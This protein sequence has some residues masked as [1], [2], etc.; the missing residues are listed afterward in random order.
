VQI[1]QLGFQIKQV[2]DSQEDPF[3]LLETLQKLE[4]DPQ[5]EKPHTYDLIPVDVKIDYP[6]Y[7]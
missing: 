7:R 4:A 1:K 5:V 3:H 6:N 2:F